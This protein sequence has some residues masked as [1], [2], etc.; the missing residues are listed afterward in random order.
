MRI[1]LA[2]RKTTV[3]SGVIPAFLLLVT[4]CEKTAIS[5]YQ[6]PKEDGWRLPAGWEAREAGG[7]RAA[8]FA[9]P[10][11]NGPEVDVS[12]FPIRGF[13]G[14]PTEILNIWRQQLKL[15]PVAGDEAAGR[16]AEKVAIGKKESALYDFTSAELV[17]DGKAKARSL[18]AALRDSGTLWFI[19]MT[20]DESGVGRQK[21][22]FVSF[23]KGLNL[24]NI[25]VPTMPSMAG[26]GSGDP[27]AHP[28]GDGAAQSS[29]ASSPAEPRPEWTIPAGWTEQPA[30][31]FLAAK[32]LVTGDG[33][34]RLDVNVSTSPGDGGGVAANIN[35]WRG[36]L[37]LSPWGGDDVDKNAQAIDAIGTKAVL[38]DFQGTDARSSRP[39]RLIGVIVPLE[40]RT[41][42][43]KMMGDE[44]LA[45]R[46]KSA[47]IKLVATAKHPNG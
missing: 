11:T 6:V 8:R 18:V 12:I 37:G 20:G 25:P 13:G 24:D 33:G 31:Q 15:E 21:D 19:K 40:G 16:T 22:S 46:E 14:S 47:L 3:L 1:W 2:R 43:Y 7:M 23:L 36:Q 32:F 10:S 45:E 26:D 9:I 29:G 4:G 38:V 30:T 41:W 5:V 17:L 28:P 39:A 34:A 27:H 44:K 42:F 35:R